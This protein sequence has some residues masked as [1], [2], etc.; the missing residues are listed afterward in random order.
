MSMSR[1]QSPR[2]GHVIL[3]SGYPVID[4]NMHVQY[5]VAGSHSSHL[6]C[7]ISHWFPCGADG[8]ADGQALI[9]D[10]LANTLHCGAALALSTAITA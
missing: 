7:D 1:H 8:L 9:M 5:Q 3:V 4:H 6:K 10:R 2:Y